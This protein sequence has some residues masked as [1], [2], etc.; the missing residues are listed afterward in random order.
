MK[1]YFPMI[2]QFL[3]ISILFVFIE[4]SLCQ[5]HIERKLDSVKVLLNRG[6]S[7][8][9]LNVLKSISKKQRTE[10]YYLVSGMVHRHLGNYEVGL[11]ELQK[12]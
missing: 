9:A 2:R 4:G 7:L 11:Q 6:E 8:S 12:A 10:R 1:I 5:N 3:I